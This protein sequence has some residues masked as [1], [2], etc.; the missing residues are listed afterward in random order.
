MPKRDRSAR[1]VQLDA[2][3]KHNHDVLAVSE[4]VAEDLA[5]VGFEMSVDGEEAVV[6]LLVLWSD[7]EDVG[8]SKG[9][10]REVGEH[11]LQVTVQRHLGGIVDSVLDLGIRARASDDQA[12]RLDRE[13]DRGEPAATA[14]V[15]DEL[16]V[17]LAHSTRDIMQDLFRDKGNFFA[18]FIANAFFKV[19]KVDK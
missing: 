3:R 8:L 2:V 4:A 5:D 14:A 17:D 9:E 13:L 15:D 10:L 11:E 16:G 19:T 18:L 12:G 7:E 1:L 6:G